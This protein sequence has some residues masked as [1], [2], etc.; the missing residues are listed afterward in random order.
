MSTLSRERKSRFREYNKRFI[1]HDDIYVHNILKHQYF[2]I[3]P[4]GD[5]TELLSELNITPED[6]HSVDGYWHMKSDISFI[7]VAVNKEIAQFRM[8]WPKDKGY[9]LNFNIDVK[10]SYV[11]QDL[12]E[13]IMLKIWIKGIRPNTKLKRKLTGRLIQF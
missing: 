12:F 6:C 2:T 13:E 10:E 3:H 4:F 9:L 1:G 7:Q 11:T 5:D 8:R